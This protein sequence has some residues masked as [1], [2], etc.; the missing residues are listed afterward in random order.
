MRRWWVILIAFAAAINSTNAQSSLFDWLSSTQDTVALNL[1][2]D[3]KQLL[4]HKSDKA[5][6]SLLLEVDVHTL[7]GR[8]RTRGN[9][10][11]E[12]CRLPSLRIKLDKEALGAAGYTDSLNDLKLVLQ[13]SD[14][15]MG[16]SYLRR[17]Q[18]VYDLHALLSTYH[19][20]TV[21][22]RITVPDEDILRGFLIETEEQLEAR[23]SARLVE[24][25]QISTRGLDKAAY[26]N[27]C[28]FNY[29]VLNT[30]WNVFNRHNVEFLSINGTNQLIPIPYDFDYAGFVGTS[31]AVP[32]E[33]HRLRSVYQP[34]FLGRHITADELLAGAQVFIDREQQVRELVDTYP[35]VLRSQRRRLRRRVN[36]F[37][38]VLHDERQLIG[39]L[40]R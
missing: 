39:L 3:W 10:R 23:Y 26:V 2:T 32:N 14:G 36:D 28:L 37:Y 18:L 24:S 4:R 35:E 11:L 25:E 29:L 16:Q 22:V 5:Y 13:C 34:R 21:P 27:M 38:K 7:P 8:I 30:D 31:Y 33:V 1:H 15:T 20:R 40:P 12:V 19:H 17:E 9:I 6:Q